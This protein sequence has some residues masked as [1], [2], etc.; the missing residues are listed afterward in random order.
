MR[1]TGEDTSKSGLL[2]NPEKTLRKGQGYKTGLVTGSGEE[3]I[4]VGNTGDSQGEM[5]GRWARQDSKEDYEG[6]GG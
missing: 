3:K 1:R 5:E 6:L 4:M 2:G